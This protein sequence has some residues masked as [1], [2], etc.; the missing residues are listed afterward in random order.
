MTVSYH[1]PRQ[2]VSTK[3]VRY[4]IPRQ[5]ARHAGC[6]APRQPPH[7]R[8]PRVRPL[9]G[10]SVPT[11]VYLRDVRQHAG[12]SGRVSTPPFPGVCPPPDRTVPRHIRC[13]SVAPRASPASS[14]AQTASTPARFRPKP[15]GVTSLKGN[16]ALLGPYSGP[17]SKALRK[18][19]GGGAFSV[20]PLSGSVNPSPASS[21][22]PSASTSVCSFYRMLLIPDRVYRVLE[23]ES[24]ALHER[25]SE[26]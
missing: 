26:G 10:L 6:L 17:V 24:G 23:A 25:G 22:A 11:R 12:V 21:R 7:A 18:S 14:R 19:W 8:H 20:T 2:S 15:Y 9:Q 1:V 16:S 3:T 5:S 13:S 4:H